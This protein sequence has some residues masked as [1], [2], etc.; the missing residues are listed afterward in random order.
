MEKVNI[1]GEKDAHII[2]VAKK[3]EVKLWPKIM[4]ID[5]KRL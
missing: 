1:N 3:I 4:I 5:F 2:N